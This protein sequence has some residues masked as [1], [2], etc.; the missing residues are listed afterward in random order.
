M[1]GDAL[2][3]I[4]G[5]L[6]GPVTGRQSYFLEVPAAPSAVALS[7][8]S[9]EA[10]ERLGEPYKVTIR[11]THPLD[12]DRAEYLN[13]DAAFVIDAADFT[14]PRKFAG[15]ISEFSRT[16]QTADFCA[17]E[18]VLDPLAARLRCTPRS[19]IYQQKTA[20]EII[21]A[22]LRDHDLQGH[23]FAIR[24]RRQ[25]PQHRFRLQYQMSD[26][27]YIRVLME[28]EGLYCYFVPGKF[29]EMVVFADDIDH[30]IYQ[31]ELRVPYRETAGLESGI[32]S[33]CA[34]RTRAKSVPA[35]FLAADYNSEAAYERFKADANV[36]RKDRTT[37]GTP[38][39]YGTHHPDQDSAKWEAQLRHEAA[40]A[41]Q[42][43][44]EGESNI[45][46]LRPARILRLD[47]ALPDAP[48]GQ[49]ITEVTHS[50]ARDQA[51]RNTYKA[52]PSDR[53]FRLP[54]DDAKWPRIAG[55]LSG[56]ITS[57]SQYQYAYLTQDGHYIVRFD[58]DFDDWPRGAES[59]PLRL[60]KPF[61]G[62]RQT[63]FHFPL[64]D[65]TEVAIAFHDGNPNRPYIAHAMHNSQQRD[66]ITSHDRWL[67]RNV[68]RT[69]A[70]NKL[71]FE[72]WEKQESIKLSTEYAGK[73]QLNL[74]Y[75]VNSQRK[76][77]GDGFEL[78]TSGWGAIRGGKGLFLSADDQPS[79]NGQQLDMQAARALLQ[80]AVLQ[81]EALG[82][83]AAA[84]Q[85]AAADYERQKALFTDTLD[86]LKQAGILASAPA[87][88][89]LVSGAD[90]Q[91]SANKT[92]T[93]T[94]GDHADVSVLKRFT[95][96]AGELVSVYAQKLGIKLF[97]ARGKVE[98]QAQSDEMRLMAAQN[99][100]VTSANGRVVIEAQ[101]ELL[102][103]C[104]GSYL[105]MTSTGIEDGTRGDRNSKAAAFGRQ[106]PASMLDPEPLRNKLPA[107][108]LFLDT[109]ASPASR[110]AIP[111]GMPYRLLADGVP[112]KQGVME[113]SGLVPVDHYRGA[114][115]YRIELA[116]GVSYHIPLTEAFRGEP[117]NGQLA[118][119]GFHFHEEGKQGEGVDRAR[120]RQAYQQL[121]GPNQEK[122]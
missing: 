72:D 18:I 66:L 121:L 9:F 53:R 89:A 68:I 108:P 44:Y 51:Y 64:I 85:A 40:I 109:V 55:T 48:N 17:Y 36:A 5:A 92:L 2:R 59:V 114:Q 104:G 105:R 32:E 23:Q 77:R 74:G 90:V 116:N 86:Q 106:G 33:V 84:A 120:H 8:V 41:G 28:Q 31:P 117:G 35:S 91:L 98:I 38:Y 97:A 29:G 80:Q 49:V 30:Y 99:V 110:S 20:P 46:N 47:V 94:A 13:R 78:R 22:I 103:K 81:A 101:K 42:L 61:A 10:V 69:Q 52:I 119:Q 58:L 62:A 3:S 63:G 112:V 11:L 15:W 113:E 82:S 76:Q 57:P 7:V 25:Y 100:T 60:A 6:F 1:A 37:Y 19:R 34:I 71:R 96:A 87:G 26:W 93:L 107:L 56:R 21:E 88:I 118:N 115:F 122:K 24:T 65:G 67:S 111:V 83:A 79:A 39:V 16:R 50:G 73:S 14:E 75:L 102:L 43:V 95:V 12:L 27:D 54:I 45:V 70:N 4:G